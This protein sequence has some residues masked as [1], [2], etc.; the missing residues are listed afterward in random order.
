MLSDCRCRAQTGTHLLPSTST[1][2]H[3]AIL[4]ALQSAQI[5]PWNNANRYNQM[6]D[7]RGKNTQKRSAAHHEIHT[8]GLRDFTVTLLTALL[9]AGLAMELG[10]T[11]HF[12]I[13]LFPSVLCRRG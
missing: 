7:A 3:T 4:P 9:R 10:G 5:P 12:H 8:N 13:L 11:R 1:A 2:K 6:Q